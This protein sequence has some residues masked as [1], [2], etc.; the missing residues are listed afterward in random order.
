M[1]GLWLHFMD[2]ETRIRKARVSRVAGAA[3]PS[4]CSSLSPSPGE[5]TKKIRCL[6]TTSTK[7]TRKTL[8]IPVG[9]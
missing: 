8:S 9:T 7:L 3:G 4:V 2:E 5:Q 6:W 1:E